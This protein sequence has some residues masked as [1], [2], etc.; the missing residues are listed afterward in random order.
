LPEQSNSSQLQLDPSPLQT[1]HWST[2]SQ[3]QTGSEGSWFPFS[4]Q[5]PTQTEGPKSSGEKTGEMLLLVLD[6]CPDG[7]A[8]ESIGI[9]TRSANVTMEMGLIE[10]VILF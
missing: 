6:T 5:Q 4:S 9:K 3:P 10:I 1:P 2:G 8:N 7:S